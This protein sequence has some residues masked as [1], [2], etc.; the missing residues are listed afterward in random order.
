MNLTFSKRGR[1]RATLEQAQQDF[2]PGEQYQAMVSLSTRMPGLVGAIVAIA[3]LAIVIAGGNSTPGL[4]LLLLVVFV[5]LSMLVIPYRALVVTNRRLLMYRARPWVADLG[6]LLVAAPLA[7]TRVRAV[8]GGW[9][10]PFVIELH[11]RRLPFYTQS[12][13]Y[14]Q[15][16]RALCQ[17][18]ESNAQPSST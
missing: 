2:E 14:W 7:Q 5:A 9:M 17:A 12:M 4:G 10:R 13:A 3:V 15:D 1:D 16:V 18:L 6:A 11:G 8:H